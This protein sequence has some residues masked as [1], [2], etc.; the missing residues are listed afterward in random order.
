MCSNT[1]L[2]INKTIC[3]PGSQCALIALHTFSMVW[4]IHLSFL[5]HCH[6]NFYL[7]SLTEGLASEE[8][9]QDVETF[10]TENPTSTAK[11]V[12]K[13]NCEAARVNAKWMQRD[14][15]AIKEWLGTQQTC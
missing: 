5:I 14:A 1:S 11:E 2:C 7:Q 6:N 9:A 13:Q 12:I 15:Q 8:E 3:R 10:F 4:N